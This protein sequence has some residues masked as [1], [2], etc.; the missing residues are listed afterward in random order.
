MPREYCKDPTE[1]MWSFRKLNEQQTAD[2]FQLED[3]AVV[4]TLKSRYWYQRTSLH[5]HPDTAR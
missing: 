4:G 1:R 2:A 3:Q 5:E